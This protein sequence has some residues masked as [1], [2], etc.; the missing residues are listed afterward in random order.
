MARERCINERTL[1]QCNRSEW[2]ISVRYCNYG[3]NHIRKSYFSYRLMGKVSNNI[4]AI[5]FLWNIHFRDNAF[6]TDNL[7]PKEHINFSHRPCGCIASFPPKRKLE[8]AMLNMQQKSTHSS[9]PLHSPTSLNSHMIRHTQLLTSRAIQV[10][11]QRIFMGPLCD[12]RLY[13]NNTVWQCV[14]HPKARMPDC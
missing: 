4:A 11:Q 12:S 8:H 10:A 2:M 7:N 1:A 3:I 6:S 5:R 13:V 9:H 14:V